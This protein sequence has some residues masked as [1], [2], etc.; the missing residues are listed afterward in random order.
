MVPRGSGRAAPFRIGEP[1]AFRVQSAAG[2]TRTSPVRRRQPA[3]CCRFISDGNVPPPACLP[4]HPAARPKFCARPRPAEGLSGAACSLVTNRARPPERIGRA[5]PPEVGPAAR[6]GTR[7][8]APEK[9]LTSARSAGRAP[10]RPSR[11]ADPASTVRQHAKSAEG[12]G[13]R[14]GIAPR[15][16][17]ARF[18]A[19]AWKWAGWVDR[20]GGSGVPSP[21]ESYESESRITP[22]VSVVAR[23]H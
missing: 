1:P 5:R 12:H 16:G 22:W 17:I 20:V 21:G 2:G 10:R 3:A 4:P 19:A 23:A 7:V 13:P 11:P 15:L 6:A 8:R 9:T 18:A 14:M